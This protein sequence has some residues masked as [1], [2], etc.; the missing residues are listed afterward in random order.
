MFQPQRLDDP[1]RREAIAGRAF[2]AS[3]GTVGFG[4]PL[5]REREALGECP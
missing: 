1:H 4:M 5:C 2:M 3:G